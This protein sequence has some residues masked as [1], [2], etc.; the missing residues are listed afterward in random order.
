MLK[1]Y[2][3]VTYCDTARPSFYTGMNDPHHFIDVALDE[4]VTGAG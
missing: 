4:S 1:L 2:S 3:M